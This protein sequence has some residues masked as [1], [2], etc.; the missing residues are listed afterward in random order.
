[1][2]DETDLLGQKVEKKGPKVLAPAE[3]YKEIVDLQ[4]R[5]RQEI[6][7]VRQKIFDAERDGD[8]TQ[9]ATLRDI[10]NKKEGLLGALD[11]TSY[12][13]NPE[14]PLLVT[15]PSRMTWT[16]IGAE[17]GTLVSL[18]N[19]ACDNT[20]VESDEPRKRASEYFLHTPRGEL[21]TT[22]YT[23][24]RAWATPACPDLVLALVQ[25]SKDGNIWSQDLAWIR[26]PTE[27]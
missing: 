2:S 22:R 26:V 8:E 3:I 7:P 15:G 19:T 24:G 20:L 10:V 17:Y 1:M 23:V 13:F 14:D 21:E 4:E 5:V 16:A 18:V 9:Q 6:L 25:H 27:T 12:V 11:I